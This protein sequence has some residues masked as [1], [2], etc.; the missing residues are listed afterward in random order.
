MLG[1]PT[2]VYKVSAAELHSIALEDPR[3]LL[4][5]PGHLGRGLI[6]QPYFL[7]Q[8]I[9]QQISGQVASDEAAACEAQR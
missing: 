6:G 2:G 9:V 8:F 7:R 5:Q 1:L 4:V 3:L